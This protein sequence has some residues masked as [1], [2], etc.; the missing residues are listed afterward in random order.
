[1]LKFFARI[2]SVDPKLI[3][4]KSLR[5]N[6]A[7]GN[8][9]VSEKDMVQALQQVGLYNEAAGADSSNPALLN[10]RLDQ[11]V[12][13]E[14]SGG[15]MLRFELARALVKKPKILFIDEPTA[16]LDP[17]RAESI[18]KLLTDIKNENHEM[19]IVC[20]SHDKRFR[21]ISYIDPNSSAEEGL[22]KVKC[23]DIADI[24]S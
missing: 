19:T 23:I 8:E 9:S 10:I 18:I 14:L 3:E 5:Y 4:G 12:E 21:G 7:L 22:K 13:G 11:V 20:I 17:K 1:M 2:G 15:Q 6:L 24:Q 16:S